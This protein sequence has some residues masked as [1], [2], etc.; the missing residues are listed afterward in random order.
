MTPRQIYDWASE[1]IKTTFFGYCTQ[2][3][4]E[5]E[6][7]ALQETLTKLEQF[8]EQEKSIHLFQSLWKQLRQGYQL[9]AKLIK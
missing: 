4:Y 2:E 9:N 3:E 5:T 7:M 1:N 8:L 6:L